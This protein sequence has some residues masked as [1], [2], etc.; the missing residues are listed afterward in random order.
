MLVKVF[1]WTSSQ[2]KFNLFQP[3]WTTNSKELSHPLQDGWALLC[4]LLSFFRNMRLPMKKGPYWSLLHAFRLSKI[5]SNIEHLLSRAHQKSMRSYHN[6]VFSHHATY[7]SSTASPL[8]VAFV[9]STLQC[10]FFGSHQYHKCLSPPSIPHLH[11]HTQYYSYDPFP[12]SQFHFLPSFPYHHTLN[13]GSLSLLH[14]LYPC[15]TP[16]LPSPPNSVG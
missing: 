6:G 5:E 9:P 2:Y 15:S 14:S 4:I 16:S 3:D 8:W 7:N 11:L 13:K 12:M 10:V 1:E